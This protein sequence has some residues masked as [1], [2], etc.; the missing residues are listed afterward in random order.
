MT[1]TIVTHVNPDLDAITAA[2]LL[3]RYGGSEFE[4]ASFAFVPAGERLKDEDNNTVHVDTGLGK[5]DHHQE[6]V[7]QTDTCAALLVL[8][9]LISKHQIKDQ[10]ELERMI[11]LIT[12]ID[13]FREFFW[14]EPTQDRYLFS[15]DQVLNG[16]KMGGFVDD[17]QLM[18]FGMQCLDGVLMSFILRV[19]AEE[20]VKEGLTF[21]SKWGSSLG[22]LSSH[23]GAGKY[24]LKSGHQIVVRKDPHNGMVRIKAAPHPEIDLTD[25]Y[26]KIAEA[27]SNATWY[28]HPSKHLILNGSSKNP[29]M[30]A[31]RLSLEEVI[32]IIKSV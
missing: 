12:D 9:W 27:D 29:D 6:D 8:E 19:S 16:M 5:F 23:S 30:K 1:K 21:E 20:V 24:A 28:F 22:L 10:V 2:W 32:D 18:R 13:H 4:H 26:K 14:P 17:E 15:L 25:V 3:V 7:G 11:A 31:S